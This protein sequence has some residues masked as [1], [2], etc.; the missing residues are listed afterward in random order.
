MFNVRTDLFLLPQSTP[1]ERLGLIP[2]ST[3]LTLLIALQNPVKYLDFM[4]VQFGILLN[5][6]WSITRAR[7]EEEHHA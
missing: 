6:I 4:L 7:L 3:N 1:F 2:H 5:A